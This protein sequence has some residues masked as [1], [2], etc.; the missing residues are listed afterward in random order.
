MILSRMSKLYS[1]KRLVEEGRKLKMKVRVYDT[2]RLSVL[3]K[4]GKSTILYRNS[5]LNNPNIVIPR[6]GASVTSFGGCIMYQMEKMNIPL[7]N[8]SEGMYNT[9][10]KFRCGQILTALRLPTPATL[11]LRRPSNKDLIETDLTAR[12]TAFKAK[13]QHTIDQLG[14][15]PVI[16]KI[17]KGTQGIGVILANTIGDVYAQ[18]DM[19][20]KRKENFIIQE[21][22]KESIGKD[23][24]ALV[25]GNEVIA[26]M[27][28]ENISDF[29]SNTHQGGTASNFTLPPDVAKLA[30]EAARAVGLTVAGVDMLESS[31]GFKII[32]INSSPGFEGLEGCTKKNVASAIM[33]MAKKIGEKK[34]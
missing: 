8:S 4:E 15:P 32:E 16:I 2:L 28:R 14:G 19:L 31:T 5:E 20:W 10:D 7:L 24:R 6:I 21:F 25:V 30:V 12:K 33:S 34:L 11:M 18:L 3:L 13:V 26:S 29:R 22:I 9:R 1:T 27:K 23:Y 17:N